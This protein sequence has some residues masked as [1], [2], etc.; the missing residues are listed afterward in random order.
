MKTLTTTLLL[1]ILLPFWHPVF[2]D[3]LPISLF[4]VEH[5]DQNIDHFLSPESPTHTKPLPGLTPAYQKA[6]LADFQAHIF[7]TH[8]DAA[9]PWS[10]H[11]VTQI[12]QKNPGILASLKDSL[13]TYSN[14]NKT[15]KE[16]GYGENFRAHDPDWITSIA[17][18]IDFAA[19]AP[20]IP[21]QANH[22]AIVVHNTSVRI[23]P[24]KD[25]HFYSYSIPGQG[26]PFD[27]LQ[28]SALWVG[29]PVYIVGETK[30]KRWSLL[31][32][33]SFMG[34]VESEAL[35]YAGKGFIKQWE[36]RA[37][38][39]LLAI[40]HTQTPILRA[41]N[42]KFQ[43]TAYVGS[44]F[45]FA[46]IE[47]DKI[48]IKIPVMDAEGNAAMQ[49]ALVEKKYAAKMPLAATPENFSMLIKTLQNRPYG[50]GGSYFYNDCSGELQNL[51]TPFGIW[52]PR[53]SSVQR[54]AGKTVDLIA[55]PAEKRLAYL[56][57]NGHPLTTLVYIG[58]HIFLYLGNYPNPSSPD[59]APM[60]MTYQTLWGLTPED[61]SRRM[62]IGQSLL[63]PLLQ[64]YPE[65]PR[66]NPLTNTKDFKVIY[67]DQWPEDS[68]R[69]PT[70]LFF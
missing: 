34:W 39:G 50:W 70:D 69:K 55:L 46:G 45:P 63:F 64:K 28:V 19:F 25:P 59:H 66:L 29:T 43:F 6:R 33:S 57:E 16:I 24:T 22:R 49:D 40:T 3:E 4:P 9:S 35:A 32:S 61:R 2:A 26:Y 53:N 37:R 18:N 58:G 1:L 56:M 15:E 68:K 67:L 54:L 10:P 65:D 14:R 27:N 36:K 52:L 44:V 17:E 60:A 8:A 30:D 42:K 11:F 13:A 12:L 7:S 41:R 20:P 51:Y 23:L 62:V 31:L 38:T 21:Y 48:K 5:Y 47:K